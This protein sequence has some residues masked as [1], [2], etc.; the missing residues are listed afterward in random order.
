MSIWEPPSGAMT[1]Q[2]ASAQSALTGAINEANGVLARA[3]NV[4]TALKSHNV[5]LNVP[6]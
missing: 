6:D 1:R 2:A 3:R 4:S 5:T